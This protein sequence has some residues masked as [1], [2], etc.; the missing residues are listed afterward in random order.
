MSV[1][2]KLNLILQNQATII[3][4]QATILQ[5]VDA[6]GGGDGTDIK[7][8]LVKLEG[9][10]ANITTTIGADSDGTTPTPTPPTPSP[11]VDGTTDGSTALKAS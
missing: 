1:E 9:Q 3:A 6:S 11:T 2:G 8:E 4:N 5:H 10:V 7:E